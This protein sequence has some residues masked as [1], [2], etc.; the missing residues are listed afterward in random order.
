MQH[1]TQPTMRSVADTLHAESLLRRLVNSIRS[2][3]CRDA[4]TL[5]EPRGSRTHAR[6]SGI[7]KNSPTGSGGEPICSP[8]AADY[9]L[10]LIH[11]APLH[12]RFPSGR[13]IWTVRPKFG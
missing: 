5:I 8:V 3:S 9:E 7:P 10:E 1:F 6:V 13:R 11:Q 12:Y 2:A 4:E